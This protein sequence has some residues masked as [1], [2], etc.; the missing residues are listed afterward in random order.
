MRA[1]DRRP[2]TQPAASILP[3]KGDGHQTAPPRWTGY[4]EGLRLPDTHNESAW[5]RREF[6]RHSAEINPPLRLG[7]AGG[8]VAGPPRLIPSRPSP[9]EG[10]IFRTLVAY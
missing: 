7:P 6:S 10:E 1:H 3:L 5:R 9:S 4:A 8:V 2:R